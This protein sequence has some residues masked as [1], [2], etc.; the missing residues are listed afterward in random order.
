MDAIVKIVPDGIDSV[1]KALVEMSDREG[2]DLVLTAGGTGPSPRDL[3]REGA[4]LVITR[5]LEV[6]VS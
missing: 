1:A 6:L 2:C 3:M 5:E 4:R